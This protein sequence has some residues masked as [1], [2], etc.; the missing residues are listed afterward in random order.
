MKLER[1]K[2]ATRNLI[3]G[4]FLKVYQILIPFVMRTAIIYLLGVQYLGLSSLFTSLLQVL[5][6]A[7]LGIGSAMVYSMYK[8]IVDDDTSKICALIKLYRLYYRVIG[9]VIAIVGIC[10][11][12]FIPKLV[13]G[14]VPADINL[15]V[16]YLLNLAATV[17]SYWLFAYKNALFE[18]HQRIDV[19]SKVTLI[20]N[21]IQ[22]G[23]QFLVLYLFKSYYLYVIVMLF[24]QVLTNIITAQRANQFYPKYKCIGSIDKKE[25]HL[26][27]TRIKDLFTSK[28]G[29]V[30]INSADTIV[31]SSFL[32][33]SMLAIYQNYFFILK[34]VLSIVTVIFSAC[35]AGIGN[36]VIVET[37][38]KIL[39]I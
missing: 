3:F 19:I 39:M 13:S 1:T 25:I 12:P 23:L 36:S 6:L 21:T 38:E 16:L 34:A 28:I 8:P 22:Y 27:N 35:T 30:I 7:E 2:N 17:L 20:T 29:A 14:D 18:A 4:V 26:I 15:Y 33:L 9:L 32:G 24:T 10:L 31:I 37:E 11:T 5:N